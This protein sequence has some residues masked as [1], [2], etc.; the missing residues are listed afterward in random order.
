MKASNMKITKI[1]SFCALLIFF[2]G[3]E[4]YSSRYELIEKLLTSD[5]DSLCLNKPEKLKYFTEWFCLDTNSRA[6]FNKLTDA[7]GSGFETISEYSGD[8]VDDSRKISHIK[9][10]FESIDMRIEFTFRKEN[11]IWYFLYLQKIDY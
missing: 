8:I 6:D 5:R 1:I 2:Q 7:Y 11:E 3:C 4:N 10:Y 9:I